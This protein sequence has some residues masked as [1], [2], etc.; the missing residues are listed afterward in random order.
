MNKDTDS[1]I[2]L[3]LK[4]HCELPDLSEKVDTGIQETLLDA[5]DLL[6][7]DEDLEKLD[8]IETSSG[9]D[10]ESLPDEK[11]AGLISKIKTKIF[12]EKK[13]SSN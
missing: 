11:K 1:D 5:E 8:N 4:T 7:E 10:N 13:D 2:E 12:K 9:N 3:W 6:F